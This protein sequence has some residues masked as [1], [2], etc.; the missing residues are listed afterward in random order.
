MDEKERTFKPLEEFDPRPPEYRNTSQA[1]LKE[2]L[3]KVRGKGLC[4]SLMLD[5]ES[6]Y[7]HSGE[8]EALSPVLPSK[9]E[10]QQ[11]VNNFKESLKLPAHKI[12]EIEQSTREQSQSS[13][14]YSARRYR[15]TASYFGEIRR[16]LPTTPPHSRV[17]NH[18]VKIVSVP[19]HRVGEIT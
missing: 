5:P 15:I 4:I 19:S 7:W 8:A 3:E 2:L 6:Q 9:Q 12:R 10:L 1:R 14:W 17:E 11:R 13:M 16:R 18:R